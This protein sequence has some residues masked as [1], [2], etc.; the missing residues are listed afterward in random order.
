MASVIYNE[1]KRANMAGEIDLNAHDIRAKLLMSNTTC[2]TQNDGI[3]E[4][5]D[6]TTLDLC[7]ATGYADVALGTETVTKVD[8]SDLAK[9]SSGNVVFS[10]LSGDATRNSVGILL[11]KYVDGTD[12]NDLVIAYIEFPGAISSAATEVTVPC[13]A[14][15]WLSLS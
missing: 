2:D 10:G 3:V 14:G 9:F 6:F 5:V 13:P 8:A 11:Y 7:D 1:F 12:A 15:G 4:V